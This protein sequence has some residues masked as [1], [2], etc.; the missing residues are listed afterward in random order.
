[1]E[2]DCLASLNESCV[3][4]VLCR[5]SREGDVRRAGLADDGRGL[6]DLGVA[7]GAATSDVAGR[8]RRGEDGTPDEYQ[9]WRKPL[10][11]KER[12]V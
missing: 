11:V 10:G 2:V 7:P 5:S 12:G 1:M 9:V 3:C 8:S 4:I 6:G